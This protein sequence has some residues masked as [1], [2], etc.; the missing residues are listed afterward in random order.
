MRVWLKTQHYTKSVQRTGHDDPDYVTLLLSIN[1][2]LTLR[3]LMS[4]H[5]CARRFARNVCFGSV[6]RVSLIRRAMMFRVSVNLNESRRLKTKPPPKLL[7]PKGWL[8]GIYICVCV[9]VC[10]CVFAHCV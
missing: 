10:V 4:D 8:I 9:C 1:N 5:C 7:S 2:M 6:C 3:W